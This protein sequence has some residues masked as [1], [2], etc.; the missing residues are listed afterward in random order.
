MT[1]VAEKF[2]DLLKARLHADQAAKDQIP[3]LCLGLRKVRI[4]L[5]NTTDVNNALAALARMHPLQPIWKDV[6]KKSR[7]QHV[8][9]DMLCAMLERTADDGTFI[10]FS[11]GAAQNPKLPDIFK[12]EKYQDFPVWVNQDFV[13]RTTNGE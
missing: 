1:R 7:V 9:C 8:I 13:C 4:P 3:A 2:Q 12:S 6:Q 11:F 10:W 5:E